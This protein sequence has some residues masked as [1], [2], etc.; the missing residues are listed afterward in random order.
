M[1]GSHRTQP[2]ANVPCVVSP[3]EVADRL[4]VMGRD[5]VELDD[6][7]SAV[8]AMSDPAAHPALY[9][10]AAR[11]ETPA[12]VV[13]DVLETARELEPAVA[14]VVA[15]HLD[16]G[17]RD[18]GGTERILRGAPRWRTVSGASQGRDPVTE[19]HEHRFSS[20]DAAPGRVQAT[21]APVSQSSTASPP[22]PGL[23]R[24]AVGSGHAAASRRPPP[25]LLRQLSFREGDLV[26]VRGPT[27]NAADGT[28]HTLDRRT[29]SSGGLK[30]RRQFVLTKS[31]QPKTAAIEASLAFDPT[32]KETLN[33]STAYRV[34]GFDF[35][36][37][38][39]LRDATMGYDYLVPKSLHDQFVLVEVPEEPRQAGYIG[40]PDGV[41]SKWRKQKFPDGC[42]LACM[43][44]LS[45][46]TQDDIQQSLNWED[47]AFYS[48]G[49]DQLPE[50]SQM[51][52][53][54]V[55][56]IPVAAIDRLHE[57]IN[58]LHPAIVAVPEHVMVAYAI[59]E[60]DSYLKV[61]DPANESLQQPSMAAVVGQAQ[62]FY[63]RK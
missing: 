1:R 15:T 36:D 18:A 13:R 30:I 46:R 38:I 32:L 61:W 12:A 29:D 7:V 24:P 20:Q 56:K 58:K 33:P 60:D 43:A 21:P 2:V 6:I 39:V 23:S 4:V 59:A 40:H 34:I 48:I 22:L 8:R 49:E 10:T 14:A 54:E 17:R 57:S 44:A 41:T 62:W 25:G 42:W 53:C 50:F 51:V 27:V 31:Y 28:G 52:K 11:A 35:K 63:V 16:Y 55:E 19:F 3:G 26:Q 9:R 37:N 47:E 45:G 5:P